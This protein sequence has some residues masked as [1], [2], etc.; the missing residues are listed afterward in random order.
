MGGV[1][2]ELLLGVQELFEL[3]GGLV[4]RCASSRT[5]GGPSAGAG[6]E[7]AAAELGGGV[8]DV[9]ERPRDRAREEESTIPGGDQTIPAIA[10]ERQ[11]VAEHAVV[12][13]RRSDT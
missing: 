9:A 10:S 8:L 5:S 13:P 2:D 11:P 7:V 3:R 12:R 6:L 4:E 1:R